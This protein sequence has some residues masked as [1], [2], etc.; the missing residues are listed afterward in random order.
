MEGI[1]RERVTSA[2]FSRLQ[3][4]RAD[5]LYALPLATCALVHRLG[6]PT[7]EEGDVTLAALQRDEITFHDL[8]E[9]FVREG[10]QSRVTLRGRQDP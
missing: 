5:R 1:T 7:E 4:G 6:M 10:A 2:S 9:R 3:L 8:F